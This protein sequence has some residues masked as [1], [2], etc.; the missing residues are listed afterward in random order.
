MRSPG[1][2]APGP[3]AVAPAARRAPRRDTPGWAATGRWSNWP[4]PGP[5]AVL[6][7]RILPPRVGRQVRGVVIERCPGD[8]HRD[9]LGA[10]RR[11]RLEL[12]PP[13]GPEHVGA[14]PRHRRILARDGRRVELELAVEEPEGVARA[15]DAEVPVTHE[16]GQPVVVAP[17]PD[18]QARAGV[19]VG[20]EVAQRPVEERVVPA[21]DRERGDADRVAAR[22]D[23]APLPVGRPD[24]LAE[25]RLAP[26]RELDQL[27]AG[28]RRSARHRRATGGP[29][30]RRSRRSTSG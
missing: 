1:G 21:A 10:R 8:R 7:L 26:G 20:G 2:R 15:G 11:P 16:V 24:R 23:R 3:P 14:D 22:G 30:D 5:P 25:P 27:V 6:T 17:R 9:R 4:Q 12:E 19:P 29:A 28:R 18:D 13:A